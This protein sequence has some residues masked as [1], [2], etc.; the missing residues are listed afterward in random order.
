MRHAQE[1][2]VQLNNQDGRGV[3][4]DAALVDSAL[5][6]DVAIHTPL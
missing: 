1:I 3:A 5:D 4:L 6:E 2:F